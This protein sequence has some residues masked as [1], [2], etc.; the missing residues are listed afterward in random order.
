ML[1]GGKVMERGKTPALAGGYRWVWGSV[2][3]AVNVQQRLGCFALLLVK[4]CWPEES[5]LIDKADWSR[6]SLFCT[7]LLRVDASE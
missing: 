6:S 1:S 2:Q 5:F 7:G 3:G 4:S